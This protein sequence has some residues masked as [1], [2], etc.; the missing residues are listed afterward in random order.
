VT[1]SRW[2]VTGARGMLGQDLVTLLADRHPGLDVTAVDLPELD[3]TDPI[4]VADLLPGHDVVVN[5]AA[6]TAVDDAETT[7]PAAFTVNAVGAAVLARVCARAGAWMLQISTDY[8]F[9]GRASSP[10]PEDGV[11]VPATAYGRTKLAGEWAV[12]AELPDR[13]WILRTAWLYGRHGG[14]FVATMA[15]LEGERETVD[16]VDDQIGQ[17][18]WTGD[19]AAR[20]DDLVLAGAPA[21]TY[22]ATAAGQ[23]SW[24]GL[25]REVFGLLGADP[26]RVRPVPSSQF[27]RPAPRPAYSV[28]GHDGWAAAGLPPMRD[29]RTAL[30]QAV[31][32]GV[33]GR[34]R[35]AASSLPNG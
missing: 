13:H 20:I 21:G 9:D 35:P 28:L 17:P 34:P 29:W 7:E 4:A 8:V 14:N 30:H 19:L 12:R 33:T 10:Y 15:R 22:H 2:L 23:V 16:V 6:W 3:I 31:S 5:C 24:C 25:A 1:G 18:T 11:P 32:Q 26:Q 27:V